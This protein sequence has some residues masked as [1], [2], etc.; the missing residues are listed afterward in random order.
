MRESE[1]EIEWLKAVL[2]QVRRIRSEM[3]ISPGKAIPLLFANGNANDRARTAKFAAQIGFLARTESQRW[4]K[5]GETEP[6]AAA[7]IVGELKLLIPLAG[8][9]D[10]GA[11]KVRLDK[12]IKR[13]AA[14]MAKCNGKLGTETFVANAPAAVVAQEKQRLAE[15]TS[16]LAGLR[17][18][19]AR[20]AA[21]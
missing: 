13:I 17:E 11:E 7:A 21:M 1:T 16:T 6:P 3:S 14:E 5:T 15:F 8:L 9:I 10:L 19:A 2:S 20:L 18:Q 4:L 12:E